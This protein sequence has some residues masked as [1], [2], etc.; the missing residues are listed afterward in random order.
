MLGRPKIVKD[1][2]NVPVY[3]DTELYK[4]IKEEAKKQDLSPSQLIRKIIRDYFASDKK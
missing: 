3:M 4:Q 1:G 2:K